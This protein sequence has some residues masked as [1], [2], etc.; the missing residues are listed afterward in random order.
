MRTI[1][2]TALLS[3]ALYLLLN[4]KPSVVK[5]SDDCPVTN[6]TPDG[7]GGATVTFNCGQAIL[8]IHEPVWP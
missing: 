5:A 8:T 7:K 2:L 4:R 3:L 6:S 1:L